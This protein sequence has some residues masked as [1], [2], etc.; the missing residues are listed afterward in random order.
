MPRGRGWFAYIDDNGLTWAVRVDRDYA[1]DPGRGWVP[2]TDNSVAQLPRGWLPRQVLG[3]SDDGRLYTTRVATTDADLWTGAQGTFTIEADD[4]TLV[5]V[6]VIGRLQ[7]RR[8][9]VS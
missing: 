1:G 5:V 4:Q 9:S 6:N 8:V 3:H 7:E 2:V